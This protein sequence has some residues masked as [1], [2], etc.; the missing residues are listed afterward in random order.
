MVM[1]IAVETMLSWKILSQ[2]GSLRSSTLSSFPQIRR[3]FVGNPRG[4]LLLVTDGEAAAVGD[5]L[6]RLEHHVGGD[7][8][9]QET[10]T[11]VQM[12]VVHIP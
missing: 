11:A 10:S 4:K 2:P 6:S 9:V 12:M 1:T 5:Q 7:T 8:P 3:H